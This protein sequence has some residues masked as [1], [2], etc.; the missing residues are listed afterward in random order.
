MYCCF[1]DLVLNQWNQ[2]AKHYVLFTDSNLSCRN[3]FDKNSTRV[4]IIVTR[5][6]VGVLCWCDAPYTG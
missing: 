6:W 2:A 1:F 3:N 4:E 5:N